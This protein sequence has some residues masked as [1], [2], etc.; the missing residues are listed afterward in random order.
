MKFIPLDFNFVF[1]PVYGLHTRADRARLWAGLARVAK[2]DRGAW[3]LGGDF[4]VVSSISEYKGPSTPPLN[5]ILDFQDCIDGCDLLQLPALGS[6][7][8]WSGM[9]SSGRVWEKLDMF[10]A[11]QEFVDKFETVKI[12]HWSKTPSDHCPLILMC[13]SALTQGPR[14]F[15]F[16]NMWLLNEEFLKFVRNKWVRYPTVG[17]MWG[18]SEKLKMVKADLKKWN[19][20]VCGNIFGDTVNDKSVFKHTFDACSD[21]LLMVFLA[22][23]CYKYQF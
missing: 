16:Q 2:R 19:K 9:R 4:N 1:S 7:F 11:N 17:G 10:L 21:R 15:R 14:Q 3:V 22:L 6:V 23:R 20:D 12:Q 13:D 8:T 18:F 5:D